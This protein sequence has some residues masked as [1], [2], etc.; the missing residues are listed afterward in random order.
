M[1]NTLTHLYEA[2]AAATE[3]ERTMQESEGEVTPDMDGHFDLLLQ[4]AEALPAAIDDVLSLVRNI[5]VRA[6]ARKA[7]AKRLADRAKRDETIAEWFK[8]Q[9]LRVMQERGLKTCETARFRA[10]AAI[11]GGKPALEL[12]DT[13]PAEFTEV[14]EIVVT[15]KEKIRAAL[16]AG[17]VLP[18]AR[19]VTKQPYLK[20]S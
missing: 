16:E 12:L 1:S 20:V 6:A 4:Q 18:F 19:F 7:E 8:G 2:S 5:E 10:T 15:D 11:P 9:V 13:V 3:L 17:T 14:Q